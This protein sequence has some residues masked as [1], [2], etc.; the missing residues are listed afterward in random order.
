MNDQQMPNFKTGFPIRN[1]PEGQPVA[2]KV[3]DDDVILVR[4]GSSVFAVGAF[5]THYHGSLADGLVVGDTVRCPLHHACFSLRTGEA[6]RAPAFDAI[7]CWQT[8]LLG[9]TVFVREKLV[10]PQTNSIG[11]KAALKSI[12]IVGG[13][14]AAFAAAE[15]LRRERYD[16]VLIMVSAD[17]WAPY[18]RPNL[19]KDY[20]AGTAPPDWI[21]LKPP[22]FYAGR[23]IDLLLNAR[24]TAIH[25]QDHKVVLDDGSTYN[26]DALLLATGAEPIHLSFPGAAASRVHYLRSFADSKTIADKAS[27]AKRV[28]VVGASFIGLEVAASLRARNIEVHVVAPEQQPLEK[29]LGVEVGRFLRSLHESHGVVFHLGQTV[30][31]VR[32]SEV[33]LSDGT[34]VD[35]DFIVVGAGVTPNLALAND[36]GLTVDQGI[37][38]NQYLETSH[39]GIYAAGDSARW[40]DARSGQTIRVEHWVVAERQGQVAAKNMLG[41]RE[42]FD[43]VPFFW[44]QHYDVTVNYVG[45]AERWDEVLIDGSLE[46]HNCTIDFRLEGKTVAVATIARDLA[47]L[48]AELSMERGTW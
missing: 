42:A 29:V 5:C 25:A 9:D 15:M 20:L 21:P 40:P 1:L 45:Y 23:K 31:H 39:G 32:D 28:V 38:V 33:I 41:Q 24:V 34:V 48:R 37:I 19:S 7:D 3:D 35:A 13:G 6:L 36:A 4:R 17:D 16:G 2:G 8:E 22:D 43:A 30:D 12:V 47:S 46:E 14:A 18:D 11:A 27:S 44:S 10:Q 26:Y